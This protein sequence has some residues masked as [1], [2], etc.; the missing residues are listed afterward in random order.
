MSAS[1]LVLHVAHQH[2]FIGKTGR[3]CLG[4]GHHSAAILAQINNQ[5]VARSE[6]KQ[7]AV[8]VS[9]PEIVDER[10][11]TQVSHV[12]VK[13]AIL[14]ASRNLVVFS[15]VKFQHVLAEM[16][17]IIFFPRPISPH[18]KGRIEVNVPIFKF[19]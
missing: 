18:I 16:A 19:A 14:H 13:Y 4:T 10:G 11:A 1:R 15:E 8:E 2:L 17:G 5:S 3:K 9:S 12:V 6:V 7:D